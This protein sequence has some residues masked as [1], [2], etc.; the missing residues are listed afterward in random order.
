[1]RAESRIYY[2]NGA[3]M[4][5]N[6]LQKYFSRGGWGAAELPRPLKPPRER[7]LMLTGL[8][9]FERQNP[10]KMRVIIH[11]HLQYPYIHTIRT[12]TNMQDA[13]KCIQYSTIMLTIS[14]FIDKERILKLRLKATL[15]FS[16]FS[17]RPP[18]PARVR[19]HPCA[20][21]QSQHVMWKKESIRIAEQHE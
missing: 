2:V 20:K 18:F 16:T 8:S 6:W 4:S 12:L 17:T 10:L 5:F 3:K 11:I 14:K 19:Q 1:M 21:T 7:R 13:I 9:A 15:E